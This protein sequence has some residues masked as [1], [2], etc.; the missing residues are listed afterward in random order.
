MF[1]L[2]LSFSGQ[3]VIYIQL[4][5]VLLHV[6]EG[7]GGLHHTGLVLPDPGQHGHLSH[8]TRDLEA[9]GATLLLQPHLP[10]VKGVVVRQG[11]TKVCPRPSG[12]CEA[13]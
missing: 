6:V 11:L 12:V 9:N 2:F 3:V 13:H 8:I 4:V 5:E 1:S 10:L 7:P